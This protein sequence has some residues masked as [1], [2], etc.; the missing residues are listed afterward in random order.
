MVYQT[1]ENWLAIAATHADKLKAFLMQYYPGRNYS[2][3]S[4][5]VTAGAAEA[6]CEKVRAEVMNMERGEPLSPAD[7][8][9]IAL[10]T[11]DWM[12]IQQ[13]LDRAWFGVPE[14]TAC[15]GI[16]GFKEAVDLLDDLPD[17]ADGE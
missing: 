6:V 10:Q 14:S 5:P 16:E 17:P 1:K 9:D 13:L 12:T 15:W 8:F 2:P 11:G 4:L 3:D 7:R